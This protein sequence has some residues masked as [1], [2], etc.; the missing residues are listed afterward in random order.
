MLSG[1]ILGHQWATDSFSAL[2][3]GHSTG[4]G[5][6]RVKTT[7]GR[8]DHVLRTLRHSMEY[9]P[10]RRLHQMICMSVRSRCGDMVWAG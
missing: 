9:G 10:A 6:S 1:L 8:P 7:R 2:L 5:F 3:A 4:C